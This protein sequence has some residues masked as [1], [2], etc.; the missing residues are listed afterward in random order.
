MVAG[1]RQHLL[2]G[3]ALGSAGDVRLVMLCNPTVPSGPVFDAFS[4]LRGN[5]NLKTITISAFDTP[6][7]AVLT[8]ESLLQLSEE[9]LDYAPFPWLI[10]R[11]WVKEM[12]YKWGPKN[13]RFLARVLGEFPNQSQ[14]AVFSLEW[15]EKARREPT[16]QELDCARGSIIQV[17]VDV[18]AGGDDETAA[19]ARVNGIVLS[20]VAWQ[21]ADPRGKLV[22]WLHSLRK[23]P[24]RLGP[25]VI[26][27]V[28]VGH[29][30][31][32]H[33]VD[34]G[35]EVFGFKAG[36]TP[37]DAEQYLNAKAEAYFRLRDMYKTGYI[38]HM[39]SDQIDDDCEAQLCTVEYR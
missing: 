6:N 8:L 26:D 30:I 12:Y 27:T 39:N 9:D 24:F 4:N 17:G 11:R 23:L 21:D 16:Q 20:R 18:A 34:C 36:G 35:F 37:M 14:W 33:V 28:G 19:C 25:V 1:C 2:Q 5:P 22:A 29:G 32:L 15:I 7:L 10:R 13:P 3:R 31:A 38:S